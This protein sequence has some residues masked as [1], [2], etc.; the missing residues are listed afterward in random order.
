MATRKDFAKRVADQA[1]RMGWEVKNRKDGGWDVTCPDNFRIQLHLTPSDVNAEKV[2]MRELENHGWNEAVDEYVSLT[3]QERQNRL[4]AAQAENQRRL[5]QAQQQADALA[6]AAGQSR[7]PWDVLLNPQPV[8][9]T[10]ERV[11]V[12]PELA[13]K[14]LDLNTG[15]RP[16][17]DREVE[18]WQNVIERG[19]FRYTHQGIAVDSNGVLQ[20]GQHRATAIVRSGIAVEMQ[21]SVGMPP[22][23]F[24]AIDNGLRRNFRDVVAR[25]G[26]A[27]AARVGSA[28]RLLLIMDEYPKRSFGDKVSNAEVSHY[29]QRRVT[30]AGGEETSLGDLIYQATVEAQQHWAAYRINVTG[31]AAFLTRVWQLLGTENAELQDF[32]AGLRSGVDLS[33]SDPRLALRRVMLSPSNSVRTMTHVHYA[34]IVKSWNKFV[35]NTPTKVLNFRPKAEDIPKIIVP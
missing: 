28:A 13:T 33:S 21:V 29:L 1:R 19:E 7:V 34:Y 9:K 16:V 32:L 35:K 20:D 15:N 23:N 2:I 17:R 24:D 30:L 31:T 25:L 4:A 11:L 27:N 26:I 6:R 8:P 14:L 12:T 10:F 3:E 22:E 5:D 18:L